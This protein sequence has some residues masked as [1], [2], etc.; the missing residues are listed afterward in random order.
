LIKKIVLS[1]L[2]GNKKKLKVVLVLVFVIIG[3]VFISKK[4][5]FTEDKKIE[6]NNSTI[7]VP[8]DEIIQFNE[9]T[10]T[11]IEYIYNLINEERKRNNL[12][13]LE[14]GSIESTQL[15]ASEMLNNG[16]LS[17]WNLEG[18]KPYIR[19]S[20]TGGNGFISESIAKAN[21]SERTNPK[22]AIDIVFQEMLD[23]ESE[24]NRFNKENILS[25]IFNKISIGVAFN[26]T[27]LYLVLDFEVDSFDEFKIIRDGN[28]FH[29]TVVC[30]KRSWIPSKIDV[31]FDNMPSMITKKDLSR[32][33]FTQI[34][35]SGTYVS[36]IIPPYSDIIDVFP[37]KAEKWVS[38]QYS[39]ESVF[40]LSR[41]FDEHGEGVYTFY[42]IESNKIWSSKSI[43]STE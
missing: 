28:T 22:T 35:D 39:F 16:F 31:M 12:S 27:S 43:W 25:P 33:P 42:I 32:L 10:E 11:L 6:V 24:W 19:Y 26:S 2:F 21:F 9:T 20:K 36:T 29:F 1:I 38:T 41:V 40:D 30:E 37:L 34:Y 4:I 8:K 3:T 17:Y 7:N 23:D 14:L 5:F 13:E 18:E 15:H